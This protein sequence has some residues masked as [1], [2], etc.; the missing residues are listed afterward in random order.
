MIY[1][2]GLP[3]NCSEYDVEYYIWM[4]MINWIISVRL[5]M[6]I[7]VNYNNKL[8][9]KFELKRPYQVNQI[10][11]N[12][13]VSPIN[14][15]PCTIPSTLQ[16]R[17]IKFI[18]GNAAVIQECDHANIKETSRTAILAICAGN[19]P[20]DPVTN[21]FPHKA[22][23]VLKHFLYHDTTQCWDIFI[24]VN[25]GNWKY[26][27]LNI[28]ITIWR[29]YHVCAFIFIMKIPYLTDGIYIETGSRQWAAVCTVNHRAYSVWIESL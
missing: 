26:I 5:C 18:T 9:L 7:F 23:V 10:S 14:S 15:K 16:R 24:F 11:Y 21:G 17:H 29:W 27:D 8:V 2:L 25:T 13:F 20:G 19:P 6:H 22:P 12:H 1:R 28:A 3:L 4:T